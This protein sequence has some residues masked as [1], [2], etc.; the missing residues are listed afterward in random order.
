MEQ[1]K[2]VQEPQDNGEDHDAV[3]NRLDG[4]LH[5]NE[6][7]HEPQKHADYDENFDQLNERHGF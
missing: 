6:P 4:C 5:R 7:I 3:Q 1:S 2:D